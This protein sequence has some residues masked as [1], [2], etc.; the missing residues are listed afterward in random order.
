MECCVK[1]KSLD[2]EV[3]TKHL[4]VMKAYKAILE[5]QRLEHEA[6]TAAV[7]VGQAGGGS[8]FK[9]VDKE[10]LKATKSLIVCLAKRKHKLKAC[11]VCPG[12]LEPNCD[13]C[14]H[15]LDSPRNGGRN[16]LR[17]KCV[18]RLCSNP[19]MSTCHS[20]RWQI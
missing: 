6:K 20:C 18:Q 17:R 2:E 7:K 16:V 11:S 14:A 19:V 1:M 10:D 13:A 15:C 3:A 9:G 12:C 5:E 4:D 8:G